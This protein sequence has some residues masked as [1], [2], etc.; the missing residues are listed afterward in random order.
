MTNTKTINW[1]LEGDV[2]IQYLT[3]KY[4]LGEEP[5][6]LQQRIA[7][8]GWGKGFL[9]Q[10]LP[11]GDWGKSFYNPKWKSTHYTLLDLRYLEIAP[12]TPEVVESVQ[13]VFAEHKGPDGGINPSRTID[14]SD[15]CVNGM[16]LLY[17]CY[18]GIN[19]TELHSVV[20]CMLSQKMDDGGF[21]CERDRYGAVHSSL[22][23]TISALEGLLEYEKQGYT[24][25]LND[26]QE[27]VETS[28][29]FILQHRLYKSDK[30]GEIINPKFCMLSFPSRWFY[31]IL[32]ALVYFADAYVPYDSRMDDAVE[33]LCSKQRKDGFW[34]I[35]AKHPGLVHFDMESGRA[36]SR[37]N[38][39][40]A[41]RV[42]DW[43]E[44]FK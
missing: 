25:R 15:T 6:D 1:L 30:T 12:D 34:P 26:I 9:S 43:V 38:T 13:K 17:G 4:L 11:N 18:F 7:T 3:H 14:I 20:D 5:P 37:W 29:E 32:R 44:H 35:Q 8:E 36:P 2:A 19:E 27:V 33:V 24:Y 28:R 23:T 39:L 31:D 42:L 22:H 41:L 10:R 16:A 21:N 40:R